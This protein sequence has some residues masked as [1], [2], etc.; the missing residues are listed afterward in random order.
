MSTGF[1][2]QGWKYGAA[3]D[4]RLVIHKRPVQGGARPAR[5]AAFTARSMVRFRAWLNAAKALQGPLALEQK[6]YGAGTVI[7]GIAPINLNERLPSPPVRWAV[8][9]TST[10][11]FETH[12][13]SSDAS[14]EP[15]HTARGNLLVCDNALR[16][17]D[18]GARVG[19]IG[20]T[21]EIDLLHTRNPAYPEIGVNPIF[22]AKPD[23]KAAR[24]VAAISLDVHP[25]FGLVSSK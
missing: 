20:D 24:D 4:G 9:L 15:Q 7:P 1:G 23:A 16:R 13:E 10:Y 3:A 21:L 12:G 14:T 25:P 11:R 5:Y 22:H 2:A 8:P 18:E 19:G 17:T 6:V